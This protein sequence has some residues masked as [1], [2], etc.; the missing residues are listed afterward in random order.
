[1]TET[2]EMLPK[3]HPHNKVKLK[4]EPTEL[5]GTDYLT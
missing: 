5:S 1:M 3:T 4:S 2:A